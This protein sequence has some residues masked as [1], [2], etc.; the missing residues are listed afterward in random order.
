[1]DPL[2]VPRPSS[3]DDD[4]F[5]EED[6]ERRRRPWVQLLL[7]LL[8]AILAIYWAGQTASR[9]WLED[10]DKRLLDAGAGANA[11]VNTL[12]RDQLSA[13]RGIAFADGFAA[14]LKRYDARD[15]ERRLTPVDANHGMPMIDIIDDQGRVVFAFRS[16]GA[17][18]PVYRQRLDVSIVRQALAGETDQYGERFSDL[19]TT[20]EGPLLATAGPVRLDGKIVGALLVMTPLDQLLSRSTNTHGALLTA[21]SLDRGDPLATTTPIRPRTLVTDLRVRLAQDGQL[22]YANRF[23]IGGTTNREQIGSLTLRHRTAAFLGAALPD[24]SRYVAWRVMVIVTIGL[25][26]MAFLVWTVAYAWAKDKY[27]RDLLALPKEPLALP[28]AP[29]SNVHGANPLGNGP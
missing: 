20:D 13:Y 8:V 7:A 27:E 25:L 2:Q 22:P 1:M 24:R 12:E 10:L 15:I 3:L 28:P 23:K 16:N 5:L 14:S 18:R 17:V 26:L 6:D 19:L 21:Y 9:L 11:T 29:D 4:L